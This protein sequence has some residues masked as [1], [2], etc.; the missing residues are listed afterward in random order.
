MHIFE[1]MVLF[2]FVCILHSILQGRTTQILNVRKGKIIILIIWL[3]TPYLAKAQSFGSSYDFLIKETN[4]RTAAIGGVNNSLRDEDVGL[5]LGNPA[6]ANYKMAKSASFTI[7]PSFAQIIQYNA[8]Y[9]DSVGK[10]GN[11]FGGIQFLN[12]GTLKQTDMY[13][14]PLGEFNANQYAITI[15]TAQRKGNFNLGVGLKFMGFQVGSYTANAA[16]VD[17]GVHY[18]HP[19][20][21]FYWGFVVKNLGLR[22]NSFYSNQKMTLPLNI[23]TSVSYKLEHMPL[24]ISATAFYIQ[25]TDIQYLNPN[26]PGTIDANG[27]EVKPSKLISEQIARHLTLGGEFLLH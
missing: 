18:Q 11:V 20:K 14:T 4:A 16:A 8:V 27:V 2:H 1:N 13:G 6:T 22:L 21:Q 25:E 9:A 17:L 26:A 3:S 10:L 24:R 7:N 12:Y 15:G 19:T 23:Q 5:V